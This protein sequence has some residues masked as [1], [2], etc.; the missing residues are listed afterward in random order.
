MQRV[1]ITRHE[2]PEVRKPED[3]KRGRPRKTTSDRKAP[4]TPQQLLYSREQSANLLGVSVSTVKR[5]EQLGLLRC[6]RPTGLPTGQVYNPRDDVLK[7]AQARGGND[8]E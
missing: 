5:M 4:P 1:K 7:I 8:E 6:V 3:R 2:H